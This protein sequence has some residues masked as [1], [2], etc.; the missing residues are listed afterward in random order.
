VSGGKAPSW[1]G[2]AWAV[3]LGEEGALPGVPPR[4]VRPKR[5]RP[6]DVPRSGAVR[7]WGGEGGGGVPWAWWARWPWTHGVV[8]R[9]EGVRGK[10]DGVWG[11]GGRVVGRNPL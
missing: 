9:V 10:C 6:V 11:A 3:L 1:V 5:D 2:R 8:R 4:P 7:A